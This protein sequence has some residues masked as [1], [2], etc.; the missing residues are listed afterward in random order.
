MTD[1]RSNPDAALQHLLEGNRR[2]AT[3]AAQRPHQ[4]H[5][6]RTETSNSQKPF[7]AII[8]CSD[9]RAPVEVIFD[10]GIGDLFVVRTAGNLVEDVGIASIEFATV[11]LGVR[12]VVVMGHHDCGAVK[13]AVEA[14][15]QAESANPD[16]DSSDTG[17]TSFLSAIITK[18]QPA[19]D[20]VRNKPG[21]LLL[22]AIEANVKAM[23]H[24][25]EKRSSII[26]QLVQ[27]GQLKI[28]Q[29][30]Y[31]IETGEVTLRPAIK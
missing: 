1:I 24:R 4:D 28:V 25:L 6:R 29:A 21:N 31:N 8:G 2:Y 14:V 10:Q 15:L 26:Y 27:S 11:G 17:N 18:I 12:L 22:N 3:D 7:A 23:A 30:V 9:S 20:K 13:T 19:V 5:T 16:T